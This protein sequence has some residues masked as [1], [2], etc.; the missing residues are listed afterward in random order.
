[1]WALTEALDD[2]ELN[3][4][5]AGSGL[6]QKWRWSYTRR[7]R[8]GPPFVFLRVNAFIFGSCGPAIVLTLVFSARDGA[9]PFSSQLYH[10]S[11]FTKTP[12]NAVLFCATGSIGLG[13]IVFASPIATQRINVVL[14][15]AV[16]GQNIAYL[17]PIASRWMW[18]KE[19]GW[20]PGAFSLGVWVSALVVSIFEC[21][22]KHR[23]FKFDRAAS[24]QL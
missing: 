18:R 15:I 22:A 12:V 10:M 20:I 1:M 3:L 19:N 9:L 17:I 6:A 5:V 2:S 11:V 4:H 23:Q 14:F 16:T 21:E 13:A 24:A 7:T 8:R